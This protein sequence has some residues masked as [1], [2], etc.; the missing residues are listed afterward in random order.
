MF[1]MDILFL[2]GRIIFGGYFIMSGINHF[3]K[4]EMMVGY[5][6]SKGVKGASFWVSI[7]GLVILLGGLGVLLGVYVGLSVLLLV[8]FLLVVSFKMHAFW[9]V[10]DPMMKMPEMV[11]FMKNMALVG[12]ALMILGIPTPWSF[13]LFL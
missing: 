4:R 1:L 3:T 12:A 13:S 8:I 2:V 7:G 6:K 9:A 10:T 11:N 5:A